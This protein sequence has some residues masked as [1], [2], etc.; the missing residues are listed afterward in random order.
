MLQNSDTIYIFNSDT[1]TIYNVPPDLI[2]TYTK[3]LESTNAQLNNW[4]TPLGIVIACLTA[5]FTLL[6]IIAAI[7]IWI[8][9][10]SF[11]RLIK[12]TK[13]KYENIFTNYI[14]KKKLELET[15]GKNIDQTLKDLKDQLT[16]A[17]DS[18]KKEIEE[19]IKELETKKEVINL[20]MQYPTTTACPVGYELESA[21]SSSPVLHRCSICN[22]GFLVY[23]SI[24]PSYD[25]HLVAG[26]PVFE[27]QFGPKTTK[28]PKCGN[29]DIL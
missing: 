2:N 5:L 16:N 22:Y 10:K 23:K 28:C 8:Q 18:Q 19:K 15:V 25:H 21:F 20:E 26:G 11:N 3:I 17:S 9:S 4:I 1:S 7:I 13:D 29:V 27:N 14:E 6:T 12:D 24:F